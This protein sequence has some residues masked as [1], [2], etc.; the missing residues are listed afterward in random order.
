[1]MRK[2]NFP[3]TSSQLMYWLQR[4]PTLLWLKKRNGKRIYFA[5]L[6]LA[7]EFFLAGIF[8]N[9]H[10]ARHTFFDRSE[11]AVFVVLDDDRIHFAVLYFYTLPLPFFADFVARFGI[12]NERRVHFGNLHQAKKDYKVDAVVIKY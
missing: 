6:K 8:G 7:A 2:L 12:F 1:M 11:C 10:E 3:S 4:H 5:E 9:V